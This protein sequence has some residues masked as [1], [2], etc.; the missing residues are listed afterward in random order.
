M[1][2]LHI[3]FCFL[4]LLT[5][6][7]FCAEEA[8]S[9]LTYD[10]PAGAKKVGPITTRDPRTVTYIYFA[11]GTKMSGEIMI[12]SEMYDSGQLVK[13]E[14]FKPTPSGVRVPFNSGPVR[15]GVE[16]T[17]HKN[18]VKAKD[19]PYQDG[20]MHGTF[21]EWNDAGQLVGQYE[22]RDGTGTKMI[23]ND[24]GTLKREEQFEKGRQHGILMDV[25]D[26]GK[27]RV[28]LLWNK[29]GHILGK[30]FSFFPPD[31]SKGITCYS[32][33]GD[34]HGP[35]LEFSQSGALIYQAWYVKA[36]K[37]TESEY[38]AA[39]SRDPT[40]P[41][42][43]ADATKYKEFATPEVKAILKKYRDLPRVKIPLEFDKT[44]KPVLAQQ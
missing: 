39:A 38:E 7:G 2:T 18:G 35:A 27:S 43:Y 30:A 13:R 14:L 1:N 15:H 40:L 21:R 33:E 32:S 8:G 31:Q 9:V 12:A 5:M 41:P 10:I 4:L 19:S 3:F 34:L 22:M 26:F 44:G 29:D 36:V 42:Y 20:K 23:Y 37:V 11:P 28:I 24:N 16:Q 6:N 25:P 17:W